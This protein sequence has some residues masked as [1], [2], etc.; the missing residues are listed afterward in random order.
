M[1]T[2]TVRLGY[3]QFLESKQSKIQASGFK[4]DRLNP[5]LFLFQRDIVE[6]A[7]QLGKA[8]IFCG[9]GLG[10]ALQNGTN[11]LT[12]N[13]WVSIENLSIGDSVIG[14]DGKP[15]QV[16]GVF[17]QGVRELYE[18]TFSDRTK[19][20]ADGDHLWNVKTQHHLYREQDGRVLTT[21]Q[22]LAEGF[23]DSAGRKRHFVSLVKP[24]EF[25]A[26][27][28][29]LDPYLLGVL[30]GDGGIVNSVLVTTDNEIAGNLI[31]PF[32]SNIAQKTVITESVS[33]FS[34]TAIKKEGEYPSN[35][36]LNGLRD[37]GLHGKKSDKKFIPKDYLFSSIDDR[38]SLL[39]GLLD[40]DGSTYDGTV[41]YSTASKQLADDV[42]FLVQSLGGTATI[43]VHYPMFTHKGEKKKGLDSYRLN[44]CL[45]NNYCPFRLQRKID[46]WIPK[47]QRKNIRRSIVAIES[48]ES[49]LA[50]CISVD[51]PDRLFVT[52][53]CVLT[54][55]TISQLAWADALAEHT[56]GKVLVVAPLSVTQQTH[57]EALKFGIISRV[58]KLGDVVGFDRIVITNYESLH[59]FSAA[60]FVGVVL[61]ESSILKGQ[62]SATRAQIIE[63][64]AK[65]QYKL[66]CTATPSPNDYMELGNH[67]EFLGVCSSTEMLATYFTHDG[68]DT[69]KWRLKGHAKREFWKWVSGWAVTIEKPSDIGYSDDGYDLPPIEY[70]E[71]IVDVVMAPDDGQLFKLEAT[72]LMDRRRSRRNSIN[73][74]VAKCA[75][76][77]N[78][79]D[80][81]WLVWCDLN[82][83]GDL[84]EDSIFDCVQIAGKDSDDAK[85]SKMAAFI[86]G[87]AGA[88]VLVSK[89]SVSGFGINLQNCHNIA[90]VGMS[91]SYEQLYQ[92]IRRCWRFGQTEQVH[93]HFITA[94]SDGAVVRNIKR[95]E[96]DM[97]VMI[98]AMI[99]EVSIGQDLKPTANESIE[100]VTDK[101]SGNGWDL[102]HGDCV[103]VAGKLAD[104]SI[105]FSC[106]SPPF[107]SL[108][109]YSNSTRDMGNSKSDT[110][111]YEHYRFL[112]SEMYRVIKPGRL[113]SF[114]CM[115]L[116]T[117]KQNDGYIGIKDFRGDLIRMC[118]SVGF[119]Y[120][121]EVVIFKDPVVAMQRTKAIGL[122][123]KQVKKDSAMSRQGIPDY[124]VTMRKPGVN[125]SPIAGKLNQ[126][127]GEEGHGLSTETIENPTDRDSINIWQRYAS[128]IWTDINPGKTLQAK[129]ARADE[130]ERH[131]CPLQLQVIER[132]LQLWSNPNDLVFSPFTGIG[133]EGY[134]ALEMGRRFVGAE[135][136][137]SYYQQAKLNLAA[138]E[139][140]KNQLSLNLV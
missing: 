94:S 56:G 99:E 7:L 128:P 8:A 27:K 122:L 104:N 25:E 55:N 96:K 110:Q 15:C 80:E 100:Y 22:I 1:T 39:A 106:Y 4:P 118:Q 121:S 42:A 28:L 26:K 79:S 140:S 111:F 70:H 71:H 123:H 2:D 83:E 86:S 21:L 133:S 105:D 126:F 24:I 36:V 113:M 64:F 46:V 34:I 63:M 67:A 119:I 138:V 85:E 98:K 135:L 78:N 16:T 31:L 134:V 115:N 60:D 103:E 112:M 93:V 117:S 40:T 82:D 108:Y 49:G 73:D 41:E 131:V 11:V 92:A 72:D 120:H 77:V 12:P 125:E 97:E 124:L 130:D 129:S 52:E 3:Q 19:I 38:L 107:S 30:I 62:S 35:P 58:T 53:G 10:K 84:L 9:C 18:V 74:R 68:G 43:G 102:Y 89:A 61:D 29:P 54:H 88:K 48:V 51:S 17:P 44:I 137:D 50:T 14:S 37:L 5:N 101:S 59:K 65:T 114:H 109:T 136:K 13:G 57:Q 95:K 33:T 20:V 32:G 47:P 69:S 45:P 6:W 132:A 76:L 66:A 23:A 91:D 116:P 90:F 75:E 127:V 87:D 139:Q 81:Q